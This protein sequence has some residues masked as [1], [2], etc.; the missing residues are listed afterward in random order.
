MVEADVRWR[1]GK[2]LKVFVMGSGLERSDKRERAICPAAT[3]IGGLGMGELPR[4]R[5][6]LSFHHRELRWASEASTHDAHYTAAQP[7]T[8][9][10]LLKAII[11]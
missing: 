4:R 3:E 1:G 11:E 2:H 6:C 7:H 9:S 8:P 10:Q 5:V